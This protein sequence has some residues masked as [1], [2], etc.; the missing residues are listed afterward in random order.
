MIMYCTLA[1]KPKLHPRWKG[2]V[3]IESFKIGDGVIEFTRDGKPH[4]NALHPGDRYK[5]MDGK[6][7][8][9]ELKVLM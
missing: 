3:E 8:K 1:R 5:V 9:L 4:V 6:V 7:I 2:R